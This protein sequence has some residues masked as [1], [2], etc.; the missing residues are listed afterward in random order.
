MDGVE[1]VSVAMARAGVAIAVTVRVV[2]TD[3]GA[4][5]VVWVVAAELV[6]RQLVESVD[7]LVAVAVCEEVAATAM[8]AL[9][10]VASEKVLQVMAA[11]K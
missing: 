2:E 4:M 11:A 8:E 5:V 10:V 1:V 9:A 7:N 6:A 3:A